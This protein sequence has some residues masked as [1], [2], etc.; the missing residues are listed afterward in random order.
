MAQP[1]DA[2][3]ATKTTWINI[4]A[5]WR[6]SKYLAMFFSDVHDISR[7]QFFNCCKTVV[8][9]YFVPVQV[10]MDEHTLQSLLQ[11]NDE[12]QVELGFQ[13][14]A[15]GKLLDSFLAFDEFTSR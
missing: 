5:C 2:I 7:I 6:S 1:I 15:V 9:A 11:M 3:I 4:V 13:K 12:V 14:C 10:V 8:K